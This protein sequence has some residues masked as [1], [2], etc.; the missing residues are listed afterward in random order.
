M[1]DEESTPRPRR[2]F[3]FGCV[4]LICGGVLVSVFGLILLVWSINSAE[5]LEVE[6]EAIRAAG[7]PCDVAELADFYQPTAAER[8]CGLQWLMTVGPLESESYWTASESLPIVGDR[9]AEVPP[10]GQ[11]WPDLEPCEELLGQYA[12]QLEQLHELADAAE[13]ARYNVDF[14]G[15]FN[16]VSYRALS[17]R[18]ASWLLSLEAHVRAHR[19][20]AR[21]A[22]RSIRAIQMTADSIKQE[23]LSVSQLC[24]HAIDTVARET[25]GEL[26]PHAD[27]SQDDLQPLQDQLRAADYGDGLYR[28][29][30]GERALLMLALADPVS[31]GFSNNALSG[32]SLLCDDYV[33]QY[34]RNMRPV[35]AAAK[36]PWPAADD[37]MEQFAQNASFA[38]DGKVTLWNVGDF[39]SLL[40]Y[41]S[42][43]EAF[44]STG[45]AIAMNRAADAAIA[46]HRY[47]RRHG[48]PP[49][50]LD[51]LVPALL[52]RV[53][54]DPFD[55]KPL[56]YEVQKDRYIIYS[57]GP[58]GVDNGGKSQ[59][60]EGYDVPWDGVFSVKLLQPAQSGD[61][62]EPVETR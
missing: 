34:L 43:H 53:P 50:R 28:A 30:L 21:G 9:E 19:G 42:Y 16:S 32:V 13:P 15:G 49:K 40:A 45:L 29:M 44:E 23:P 27:F 51:E 11:A 35:V 18:Y 33:A 8:D 1:Q 54:I 10:P 41:P 56:R 47:C 12:D 17:M 52:P 39:T 26:L 46:V 60:P 7:E 2:R 6:L 38:V 3:G 36:K 55:G 31:K 25:L 5:Q 22:A 20:D 24:R 37:A 62:A 61:S 14:R 4:L 48:E 58:N 57:V 59:D